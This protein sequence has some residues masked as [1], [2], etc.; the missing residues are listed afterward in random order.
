MALYSGEKAAKGA[1]VFFSVYASIVNERR[2]IPAPKTRP[3]PNDER[4]L[5]QAQ[6]L[7]QWFIDP[8]H[9]QLERYNTDTLIFSMG[10]GLRTIPLAMLHDGN[11]LQHQPLRLRERLAD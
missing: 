10:Q 4:Y 3:D 11:Q 2:R 6:R 9:E 8:I 5:T 1:H 7:Y